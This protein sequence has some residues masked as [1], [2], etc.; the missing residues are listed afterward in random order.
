MKV[1]FIG[2]FNSLTTAFAAKLVRN[3]MNV[4]ISNKEKEKPNLGFQYAKYNPENTF[5]SKLYDN[6]RPDV[7]VFSGGYDP[8]PDLNLLQ[9]VLYWAAER[10]IRQVMYLS[11]VTVYG[12]QEGERLHREEDDLDPKDRKSLCFAIGED[13]CKRSAKS[14]KLIVTIVRVGSLYGPKAAD[15]GLNRMIADLLEGQ[16]VVFP[17]DSL[18]SFLQMG[19]VCE[20]LYQILDTPFS[21]TYN[22]SAGKSVTAKEMQRLLEEVLPDAAGR[23]L[24]SDTAAI[25]CLTADNRRLLQEYLWRERHDFK[26]ELKE[27]AEEERVR[28]RR[29]EATVHR[30]ERKKR[31]APAAAVMKEIWTYL[32][33]ILLFLVLVPVT[34]FQ[35]SVDLMQGVDFTVIYLVVIAIVLDLNQAALA[36][37]LS[38][39]LL[40]S[41]KITA[42]YDFFSAVINNQTLLVAAEYCIVSLAFSYVLQRSRTKN[43]LQRLEIEEKN[44]DM[45]QLQLLSEDN[46]KTRHFF[47][48][49]ILSYEMSL[50]RVISMASRLDALE[51]DRIIP[52]TVSI[53]S[54]SLGQGDTAAY[55]I[56]KNGGRMRL[57]YARTQ[58]SAKLGQSPKISDLGSMLS[59]LEAGDI[60]VN[61]SLVEDLPS[62]ASGVK[63]DGH[64]AFVFT[65]WN[66]PFQSMRQDVVNLLKSI[67]SL[68][69]AAL[70]RAN[71]YEELTAKDRCLPGSEVIRP[72]HFKKLCENQLAEGN[73]V[74][75]MLCQIQNSRGQ[76]VRYAKRIE[77]MVRESDHLGVDQA[78]QLYIL[79]SGTTEAGYRLFARRLQER[80]IE[81]V[82]V[83]GGVL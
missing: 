77:S 49:Q 65:V 20:A 80:G 43:R 45:E 67:T 42:G 34:R 26:T 37:L 32:E 15:A 17:E 29:R 51:P 35:A 13:I 19:D 73:A 66:M 69:A 78:G 14:G 62:L 3:G 44:R 12:L 64:L 58:E 71:Q 63:I 52:Q 2:E 10:R 4:A 22:V 72:A 1:L 18:L 75:G 16:D 81:S 36:L 74:S 76:A 30:A 21:E 8:V 6:F 33:T 39:G 61:L 11:S 60:F 53:I 48:D 25:Q 24:L 68:V 70:F 54:E 57:S 46:R 23:F 38:I 31:H 83:D 28:W 40:V 59:V 56:G 9:E 50:P 41:Q 7:I 27:I 82:P 79:L 55:F 5:L 47:E